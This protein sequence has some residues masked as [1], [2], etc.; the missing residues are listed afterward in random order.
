MST[1]ELIKLALAQVGKREDPKGSNRGVDVQPYTGG[2]AEPWCAHFVAWLF[3][4]TG[5]PLPGDK[6][7]TPKQHNPLASVTETERMFRDH[8][9][10]VREPQAGG[11]V[12]YTDRGR[13]DRGPGRH[14][15]FVTKVGLDSFETVEGNWGDRVCHRVVKRSDPKIAGFGFRPEV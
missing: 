7:P 15:G 3:R 14:I 5:R 4:Q 6:E 10:I 12:F 11:V 2:R 8:G 13:S 1:D 9:W